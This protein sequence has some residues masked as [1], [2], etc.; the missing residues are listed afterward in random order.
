MKPRDLGGIWTLVFPL[1][2]EDPEEMQGSNHSE[3]CIPSRSRHQCVGTRA[4]F[5]PL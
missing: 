5:N 2:N 1:L 3:F 4:L